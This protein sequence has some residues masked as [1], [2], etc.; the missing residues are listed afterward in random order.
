LQAT[1][2]E[3]LASNEELQSTNEELQSVNEELFTVNAE[4]QGK[5]S[6]LSELNADMENFMSASRLVALF[7]DTGLNIR[8]FTQNA[9]YLFNI[10]D[11]DINRPFEHISHRIRNTNLIAQARHVMVSKSTLDSEVQADDGDWYHMRVMPYMLNQDV[12]GGVMVVL[13]EIN[14]LKSAQ[15]QLTRMHLR[16]QLAQTLTL[17]ATWDWDLITNGMEWSDNTESL[18]GLPEGGLEHTHDAFMKSVH[19]DDRLRLQA[20]VEGAL[21]GG[22]P[23]NV[24]YRVIWPDGSVHHMEQRGAVLKDDQDKPIHLLGVIHNVDKA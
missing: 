16:K 21:K 1:N 13:H 6:E 15:T 24:Q 19:Q 12:Q 10:L 11:Q 18:L 23:Y 4:Y 2:E 7:L 17:S 8:R 5:I 9:K 3:L 20:C 22:K 14:E